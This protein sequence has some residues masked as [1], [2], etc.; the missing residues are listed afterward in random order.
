MEFS[1]L[2]VR[3][4]HSLSKYKLKTQID[5]FFL[6]KMRQVFLFWIIFC[7]LL[8]LFADDEPVEEENPGEEPAGEPNSEPTS[9]KI[10][11]LFTTN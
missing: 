1:S 8:C 3:N 4:V 6:R 10:G 2:F 11:V 9:I 5:S 7:L